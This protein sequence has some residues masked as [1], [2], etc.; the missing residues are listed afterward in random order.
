MLEDPDNVEV[1]DDGNINVTVLMTPMFLLMV[2]L[3]VGFLN[4][5]GKVAVLTF[6]E[7]RRGRFF[8]K[9]GI[10]HKCTRGCAQ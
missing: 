5:Q 2:R 6:N 7:T 1:L 8:D 4:S 10:G 9:V 3:F